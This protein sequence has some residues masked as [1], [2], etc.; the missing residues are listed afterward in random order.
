MGLMVLVAVRGIE[1]LIAFKL[2]IKLLDSIVAESLSMLLG[3]EQMLP[4]NNISRCAG[5]ST[6]EVSPR[7]LRRV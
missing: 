5:I 6:T 7:V 2:S 4:T 3:K 1:S